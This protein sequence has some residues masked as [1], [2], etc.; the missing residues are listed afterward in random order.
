M[1]YKYTH[2]LYTLYTHPHTPSQFPSWSVLHTANLIVCIQRSWCNLKSNSAIDQLFS[3]QRLSHKLLVPRSPGFL[4]SSILIKLSCMF[5]IRYCIGLS[6]LMQFI[7]N[8][9]SLQPTPLG[10]SIWSILQGRISHNFISNCS[11]TV[12]AWLTHDV[13][14]NNI[15]T[16][17]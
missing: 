14:I 11:F 16:H 6:V 8:G 3:D 4:T 13:I 7:A 2:T 12:V 9:I 15:T 17:C 10:Q 5:S 1:E